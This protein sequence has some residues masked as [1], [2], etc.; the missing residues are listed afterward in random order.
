MT[1]EK[2]KKIKL[3]ENIKFIW[4][5]KGRYGWAYFDVC[6]VWKYNKIVKLYIVPRQ[7]VNDTVYVYNVL[8]D[9]KA[10][11]FQ[12][13]SYVECDNYYE[14][15]AVVTE[16]GYCKFHKAMLIKIRTPKNS[17]FFKLNLH[18]GNTICMDFDLGKK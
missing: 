17:T 5:D 16:N 13:S 3:G 15:D 7:Q 2:Q 18:F 11:A 12:I 10:T 8:K 4:M 9:F 6:Q 14:K 1:K